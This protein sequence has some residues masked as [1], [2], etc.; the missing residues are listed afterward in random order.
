VNSRRCCGLST[1]GWL[2]PAAILALLP[3]CPVCFAAYFAIA[4]GFGI[5]FSAF[6][7]IRALLVALCIAS[8][9]YAL[10]RSVRAL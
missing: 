7:Y 6:F 4:A 3:K 8:V 10:F 9:A 5:S 1:A 2:A